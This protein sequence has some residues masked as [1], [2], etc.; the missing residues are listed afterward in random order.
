MGT[1]LYRAFGLPV[2]NWR[3]LR[4]TKSFL[5]KHWVLWSKTPSGGRPRPPIGLCFGSRFLEGS[6]DLLFEYLSGSQIHRVNN[7]RAF[8]LAWLLDVCAS[9]SDGRQAIFRQDPDGALTGIFIDHGHMF[10][11]PNGTD[12]PPVPRS[13]YWDYRIYDFGP[14]LRFRRDTD[15]RNL[16]TLWNLARSLP[17]EWQTGPALQR[18]SLCLHRLE[19]SRFLQNAE[20]A[21]RESCEE[22]KKVHESSRCLERK[23]F[24]GETSRPRSLSLV[25]GHPVGA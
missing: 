16:G 9:N 10:G 15:A 23:L 7:R 3:P 25:A 8:G 6:G 20:N 2:A 1:E 13:R 4:V 22:A 18:L 11:G 17:Q 24:L 12:Q 14:T 19:D 21:I 5:D